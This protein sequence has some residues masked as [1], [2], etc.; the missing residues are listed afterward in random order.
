MPEFASH[1]DTA[2]KTIVFRQLSDHAWSYE[3]ESDP[4][5]GVVIGEHAAMVID[6]RATPTMAED[7]IAKVR[8]VTDVP[9]R[10]VVLTHYHAVRVL[11][12]SAYK[13]A[14]ILAHDLVLGMIRERGAADW[15]SEVG[16][17]PRLFRDADSIPGLTW[18]D[19]TFNGRM[20]V[21][22]G[23]VDVELEHIG[24]GHTR[25]D[26][27]V[28]L[29][30]EGVIF[31]GDLVENGAAVYMGDSHP[32]D[33][34]ETLERLRGK[35][36]EVL[37]PGR[38]AAMR[39]RAE[40]ERGIDLT[41]DFVRTTWETVREVAQ[42]GGDLKAAWTAMRA[43]MDPRFGDWPIYEHC[44]PFNCARCFDAARDIDD[45]VIWTDARD[46]DVWAALQG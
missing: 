35:P 11:G 22:L 21:H 39:G 8:D 6:A 19:V 20:S 37:V 28:S 29:P 1:G 43:A 14:T 16:R 41:A 38:G 45:P 10:Y 5:S 3:A 12:A 2:E 44:I 23:G 24:R 4:T 40:I 18:P 42:A 34:L 33:W 30:A 15:A 13:G 27:I 46:R 9:I 26:T 31:G 36:A 25:G 17:F 32:A 7:V